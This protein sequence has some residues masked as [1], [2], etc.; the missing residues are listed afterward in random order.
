MENRKKGI[1]ILSWLYRNIPNMLTCSRFSVPFI[2]FSF[3]WTLKAKLLAIAVLSVTDLEG[4]LAKLMKCISRIGGVLDAFADTVMKI[5]IMIYVLSENFVDPPVVVILP[6]AGEASIVLLVVFGIS[7]ASKDLWRETRSENILE[8][9]WLFGKGMVKKIIENIKVDMFGK[10]KTACYYI[11][12]AFVFAN[13]LMQQPLLRVG[14]LVFFI[15][16]F[17]F[18]FFATGS[19]YYK[20]AKKFFSGE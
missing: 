8:K 15:T 20:E 3:S 9:L 13:A 1:W 10:I 19:S 16:G 6:L 14:Y 12:T 11:A 4:K 7:Y 17:G 2:L 18:F 5:S